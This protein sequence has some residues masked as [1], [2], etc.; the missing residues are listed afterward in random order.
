MPAA[1]PNHELAA[2]AWAKLCREASTNNPDLRQMVG[3]A[4]IVDMVTDQIEEN[5]EPGQ[6]S[7]EFRLMAAS[8]PG[9]HLLWRSSDT[10]NTS[11]SDPDSEPD[12]EP[13]SD[14]DSDSESD[15]S[16]DWASCPEDTFLALRNYA[17]IEQTK[18]K[19]DVNTSIRWF[20]ERSPVPR[21]LSFRPDSQFAEPTI[22]SLHILE[23]ESVLARSETTTPAQASEVP[24]VA[25]PASA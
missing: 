4:G 12:S 3:H 1:L 13:D 19:G 2:L 24:V 7:I 15:V 6:R 14:S 18:Q 23:D 10:V 21:T 17:S 5:L 8:K 9:E 25:K 20:E 11:Y 16:S 22:E